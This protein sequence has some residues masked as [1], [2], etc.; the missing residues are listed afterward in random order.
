MS[1]GIIAAATLLVV[2]ASCMRPQR[3]VAAPV[4]GATLYTDSTQYTAHFT[5][6][7]WRTRIGYSFTNNTRDA[8]SANYCNAPNP[9]ALEQQQADGR[10]VVAYN[11]VQLMCLTLP[12]FRV[13]A[14]ETYRGVLDFVAV[15]PGSNILPTLAVD[16]VPGTYR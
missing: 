9:P 6:P 5:R 12:P 13:A 8:V 16:S 7:F 3:G 2:S 4:G 15:P 14:G 1:K 10:W 11:P